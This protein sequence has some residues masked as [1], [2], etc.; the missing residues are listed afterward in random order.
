MTKGDYA[1]VVPIHSHLVDQDFLYFV[2][3]RRSLKL[4]LFYDP[5]RARGGTNANPQYQKVGE[6]I[7]EWVREVLKITGVAP[8]HGWRHRFKSVARDVG[9]HP[10]VEKF[11]TGHGGSDDA[12]EIEK[13]SLRYG[14]KWVKTL[15]RNIE[16]YPRYRIAALQNPP[17]PQRRVRR[18]RAQ[19]AAD[20]AVRRTGR[21]ASK[22]TPGRRV[23][24]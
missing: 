7:G 19:I 13:V 8:N 12:G 20:E 3:K 11:I 16:M 15:A 24:A 6:R 9:M 14:D 10:E 4:P 18:T 23:G 22:P 17:A 1:R 5:K 21:S 2:E